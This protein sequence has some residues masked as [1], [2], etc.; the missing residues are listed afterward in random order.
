MAIIFIVN[1]EIGYL[2]PPIGLNLFV[3]ST[4]FK[5]SMGEIVRSVVPFTALM[6]GCLIVVTYVPTVSLGL[7][8]LSKGGDFVVPFAERVRRP[9]ADEGPSGRSGVVDNQESDAA[10]ESGFDSSP[11]TNSPQV[12]VPPDGQGSAQAGSGEPRVKTLDELMDEVESE[13]DE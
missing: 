10:E 7:V 3:A 6:V 8:S 5:K 13:D 9:E 4:L 1:L 12:N 2:T 11:A